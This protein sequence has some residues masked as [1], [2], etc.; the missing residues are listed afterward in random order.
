MEVRLVGVRLKQ[1]ADLDFQMLQ[2]VLLLSGE[3]VSASLMWHHTTRRGHTGT[4]VRGV[5]RHAA[6]RAHLLCSCL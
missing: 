6:V 3:H 5:C 1:A 4:R 2:R